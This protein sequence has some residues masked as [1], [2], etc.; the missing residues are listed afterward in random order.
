METPT[1]FVWQFRTALYNGAV[2]TMSAVERASAGNAAA[3]GFLLSRITVTITGHF[4]KDE[5]DEYFA[6]L[7]MR[8]RN[9]RVG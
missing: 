1:L 9:R 7:K 2:M 4:V 8:D 3:H 6:A 5:R